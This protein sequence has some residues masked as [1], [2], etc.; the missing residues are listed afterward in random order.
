VFEIFYIVDLNGYSQLFVSILQAHVNCRLV[1]SAQ[2]K[3]TRTG[4]VAAILL[5]A[6][7]RFQLAWLNYQTTLYFIL[8]SEFRCEKIDFADK[9]VNKTYTTVYLTGLLA[10][11]FGN[12]LIE[13]KY[14]D[15]Q[16]LDE[17]IILVYKFVH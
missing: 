3:R 4:P 1:S 7:H 5:L 13:E 12:N 17:A 2:N 15:N 14:F 11:L 8:F 16:N 10:A 9:K 6:L